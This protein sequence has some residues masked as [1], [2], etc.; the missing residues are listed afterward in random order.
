VYFS[1]RFDHHQNC[2][3]FNG[4][5]PAY[6]AEH[7]GSIPFTRYLFIGC[8]VLGVGRGMLNILQVSR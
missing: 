1:A 2:W 7:D 8:C 6:Q 5:T 4:R 3:A